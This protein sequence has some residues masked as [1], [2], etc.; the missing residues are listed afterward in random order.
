VNEEVE[1]E[2]LEDCTAS[3]EPPEELSKTKCV[4]IREEE[5]EPQKHPDEELGREG[6]L[7]EETAERKLRS[8]PPNEDWIPPTGKHD[9]GSSGTDERRASIQRG[10]FPAKPQT[11][12]AELARLRRREKKVM[13]DKIREEN[14][15]R[16]QVE[17]KPDEEEE[18]KAPEKLVKIGIFG[19]QRWKSVPWRTTEGWNVFRKRVVRTFALKQIR[20]RFEERQGPQWIPVVQRLLMLNDENDYRVVISD[21]TRRIRPGKTKRKERSPAPPTSPK[22]EKPAKQP[23]IIERATSP[24]PPEKSK[25]QPRKGEERRDMRDPWNPRFFWQGPSVLEPPHEQATAPQKRPS[26]AEIEEEDRQVSRRQDLRERHWSSDDDAEKPS[27][28]E[29]LAV[30]PGCGS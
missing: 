3:P 29:A 20:W 18:E 9:D 19:R 24:P 28:S 8:P 5:P 7:T 30:A 1:I 13:F 16:K 25:P 26:I 10:R 21:K 6:A 14:P 23:L 27:R 22:I 15:K 17:K 11:T 4:E 2:G 12:Q